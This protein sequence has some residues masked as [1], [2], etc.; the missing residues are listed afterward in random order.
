[1][2]GYSGEEVMARFVGVRWVGFL[3]KSFNP[4]MLR[5]VVRQV[6]MEQ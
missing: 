4:A 2:S 3:A 5:S 1:M 6:L